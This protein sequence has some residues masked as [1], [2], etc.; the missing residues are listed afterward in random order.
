[1][2]KKKKKKYFRLQSTAAQPQV[3]EK[4]ADINKSFVMNM[5][6]GATMVD[7]VIPYPYVLTEEQKETVEMLVHPIEKFFAVSI[8]FVPLIISKEIVVTLQ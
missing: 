8:T 2:L 4:H 6:K 5:F 3:A 1:M 7:Q